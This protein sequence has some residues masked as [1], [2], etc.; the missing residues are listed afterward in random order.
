MSRMFLPDPKLT[1]P[2]INFSNFKTKEMFSFS[3]FLGHPD[4]KRAA[5]TPVIDKIWSE[6]VLRML[7][8]EL[9]NWKFGSQKSA[10]LWLKNH[11]FSEI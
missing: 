2:N 10:F 7:R 6:R 5:A 8:S 3:N 4:E 9:L 11:N 1:L